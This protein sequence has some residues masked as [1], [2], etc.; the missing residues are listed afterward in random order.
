MPTIWDSKG[1]IEIIV[2][3]QMLEK[4]YYS[5]LGQDPKKATFSGYKRVF[6]R[7]V[8][9]FLAEKISVH[10]LATI[11]GDIYYVFRLPPWFDQFNDK[12]S[13]VLH[14]AS[15]LSY[16]AIRGENDSE[17]KKRYQDFLQEIKEYFEQNKNC[18]N[19]LSEESKED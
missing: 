15:D 2:D 8:Q 7:A 11:A 4:N 14:L 12:L 16:Y 9:D 3:R 5:Q 1:T 17:I 18:L 19:N 13:S 6:L 10:D